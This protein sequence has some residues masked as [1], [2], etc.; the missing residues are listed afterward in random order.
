MKHTKSESGKRLERRDLLKGLFAVAGAAT[1]ARAVAACAA[2]T[3]GDV[4]RGPMRTEP[5]GDP[6]GRSSPDAGA[7]TDDDEF[8][9]STGDRPDVTPD[10]AGTNADWEATASALEATGVF[11]LAAPGKWAGK[12]RSHVPKI[13]VQSDGVAIVVVEHVMTPAGGADAGVT[14]AAADAKA[15][16]DSGVVPEHYVT[17]IWA[18]D[19]KGRVVFL[20][21]F[22]SS[23]PS[24]PFVAFRI[25]PGTKTIR[26]FE[27]CNLHGVWASDPI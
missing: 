20:K 25:P 13:T 22:K 7:F 26:A 24:P 17:T 10:D 16:G 11:T 23:D 19:D 15:S 4:V 6:A 3:D 8:V 18:R 21:R 1:L 9:K 12:E 2:E 27:Q 5:S 14:D